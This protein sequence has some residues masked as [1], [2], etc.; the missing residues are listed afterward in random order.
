MANGR[1]TIKRK[2][3]TVGRSID[4]VY[5]VYDPSTG[6]LYRLNGTAGI[7]WRF[8]WKKRTTAELARLISK[9]YGIPYNRALGDVSEFIR[10]REGALFS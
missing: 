9:T 5:Y 7:I 2:R 8:L 4:G 10:S 1:K 3:G 6:F